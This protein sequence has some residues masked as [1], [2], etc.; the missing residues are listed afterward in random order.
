MDSVALV[1][2]AV[3]N[4]IVLKIYRWELSRPSDARGD[5]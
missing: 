4:A 3:S 2:F 5:H 1:V